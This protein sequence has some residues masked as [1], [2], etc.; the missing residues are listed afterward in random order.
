MRNLKLFISIAILLLV[1]SET[2]ATTLRLAANNWAPYVDQTLPE[3]GLALNLVRQTF[4]RAG[5]KTRMTY[6][7]W[8]R[9]LE[10]VEIGAFDVIAAAWYTEARARSFTFSE[11]Y[12]LDEIKFIKQKDKQ[13]EYSELQDLDGLAVGVVEQYAYGDEFAAAGYIRKYPQ[14]HLIMNLSDL[15]LG[16]IDLTLDDEKVLQYMVNKQFP[17]SVKKLEILPKPLTTRG[18]HIAIS[19]E[20]PAHQK[21]A[22]DFNQALK[23]MKA[24]GSYQKILEQH[25]Y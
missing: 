20:N 19:K 12:L 4:A 10:G 24:D 3:G 7:S 11:P 18:L 21:I 2:F 1:N 16:K 22:D 6:E 17:N 8:P 13:L 9:T 25:K 14:K 23:A 5:Y 15:L